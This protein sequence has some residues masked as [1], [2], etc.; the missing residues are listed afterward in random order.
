M[1][2]SLLEQ[3][4]ESPATV[5]EGH[6]L[7]IDSARQST[8]EELLR[9]VRNPGEAPVLLLGDLDIASILRMESEMKEYRRHLSEMTPQEA[10]H[11]ALEDFV[12]SRLEYYERIVRVHLE[13]K[14]SSMREA[15]RVVLL[16]ELRSADH[17]EA[18][19]RDHRKRQAQEL[20]DMMDVVKPFEFV[21]RLLRLG[22]Y[23][24]RATAFPPSA[25]G[26]ENLF[27]CMERSTRGRTLPH[28]LQHCVQ[29]TAAGL[30]VSSQ[31][32]AAKLLGRLSHSSSLEI[33]EQF[34]ALDVQFQS[35]TPAQYRTYIAS[36]RRLLSEFHQVINDEQ[37]RVS[38]R[39]I[40]GVIA[41]TGSVWNEAVSIHGRCAVEAYPAFPAETR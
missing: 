5:S 36:R 34:A 31:E 32:L 33:A 25:I 24:G 26:D 14:V 27:T 23:Q 19:H 10:D 41:E 6:Q 12:M 39:E 28:L 22:A 17:I 30:R 9:C 37:N 21:R 40:L 38:W 13:G 3:G 4:E 16:R 18:L 20:L 2:H 1:E 35:Y 11:Y 8:L 15:E 7:S 29:P